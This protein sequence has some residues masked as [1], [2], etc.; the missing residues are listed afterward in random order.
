MV[1]Y[2]NPVV[3]QEIGQD[4]PIIYVYHISQRILNEVNKTGIYLMY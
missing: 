4:A 3:S 2:R 1:G